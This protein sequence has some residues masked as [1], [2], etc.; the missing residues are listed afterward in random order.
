MDFVPPPQRQAKIGYLLLDFESTQTL[1]FEHFAIQPT[2]RVQFPQPYTA[3]IAPV[4][5]PP[6]IERYNAHLFTTALGAVFSFATGRPVKSPRNTCFFDS[7]LDEHNLFALGIHFPVLCAGPGGHDCQ[8]SQETVS[9]F[10]HAV[11]QITSILFNLPYELYVRVM[12]TIRLIHLAHLNE[13][14][15]FAL[16]YYLLISAIESM[17]QL[18]IERKVFVQQHP[19]EE[20]WRQLAESNKRIKE[21]LNEYKTERDK[22]LHLKKRF[23]EFVLQYCPPSLW[24]EMSHPFDN[25]VSYLEETTGKRDL[26]RL[27]E[28]KWYE[29]YP[30][31][32]PLDLPEN[33]P[34]DLRQYTIRKILSDTYRYR[35]RF[36]HEGKSP[37]HQDPTGH[38]KYFDLVFVVDKKGVKRIVVPNFRLIAFIAQRSILAFTTKLNNTLLVLTRKP[39]PPS[40][41]VLYKTLY[42]AYKVGKGWVAKTKLASEMR[43]DQVSLTGILGALGNRVNQTEGLKTKKPGIDLLIKKDLVNGELCYRMR[44]ELRIA[45]DNL[46]DLR[47]TLNQSVDWIYKKHKDGKGWLL[48]NTD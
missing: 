24:D 13:R 1:E 11:D 36:T 15:D 42:Q 8:L 35:S 34:P 14:E 48:I 43:T 25:L 40:Q 10:C 4:M 19:S 9:R 26:T 29:V 16:A 23:V 27:T 41:I 46:P 47:E 45:I 39:I 28:K 33:S 32:L 7:S 5:L 20:E 18:A 38:N 37:P 2:Q 22:S 44:P 6:G 30:S 3:F 12:Q 31:D 17:A 21:L